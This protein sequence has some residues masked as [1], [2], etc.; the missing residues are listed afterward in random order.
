[1]IWKEKYKIGVPE[2]DAQH[3]ELFQRLNA[4]IE[5]IHSDQ[6]MKEKK[7]E[8]FK[9]LEFM[10][11]YV[12]VHFDSEEKVQQKYD[13]PEYEEHHQIHEEFKNEIKEFARDFSKNEEDEDLAMVFSGRLLTWLI[14]HVTG[15][16]Q[17]L[18]DHINN[19]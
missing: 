14:K 7:K 18:A 16:D 19:I 10:Q 2:V 1:M 4:F 11:E 17:K 5:L 9:T 12:V 13:F 3:K 15:D 6:D 8:L